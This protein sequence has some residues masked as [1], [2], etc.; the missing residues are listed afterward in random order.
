M[1]QDESRRAISGRQTLNTAPAKRPAIPASLGER[2]SRL[3][4]V[5]M[6]VCL[7]YAILLVQEGFVSGQSG[8]L[9]P[10]WVIFLL[11]LI[12]SWL[13]RGLNR[14]VELGTGTPVLLWIRKMLSRLVT[15]CALL[16]GLAFC[17]W[18]HLYAQHF[19]LFD[20][21][22]LQAFA[23][24][25]G[26]LDTMPQVLAFLVI[27]CIIA[28]LSYLTTTRKEANG[29]LLL[30]RGGLLLAGLAALSLVESVFGNSPDY[31]QAFLLLPIFCW[32]G[33]TTQSLQ[34]ASA[35][36]RY[37]AVRLEGNTRYQ[38]RIIFRVM[39]LFGLLVLATILAVVQVHGGVLPPISRMISAPVLPI[40]SD[41]TLVPQS[42]PSVPM[43][44]PHKLISNRVFQRSSSPP[45]LWF[46]LL[47]IGIG[48]LFV[49]LLVVLLRYWLKRRKRR[50]KVVQ[51]DKVESIW[52]WSLF[53][54][55]FRVLLQS[56]LRALFQAVLSLLRP[57]R[58]RLQASGIPLVGKSHPPVPA[59]HTIRGLYRAFL[60]AAELR[61]YRRAPAETPHEFRARL[62]NQEP[63]IDPEL[64]VLTE[65]YTL[66][67]YGGSVP[68]VDELVRIEESWRNLESKW[69]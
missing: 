17:L 22:W 14:F 16:L 31:W 43:P 67:R 7:V 10:I 53:L 45:P 36:R 20:S 55:Q 56:Q 12:F 21:T 57:L 3:L 58:A 54:T 23:S 40:S 24:D 69:E 39:S 47:I 65:A 38:E 26:K 8:P 62:G 18:L 63:L 4:I 1:Q 64:G 35:K 5:I 49:G 33:L 61:G 32:S 15:G 46:V 42:V 68:E 60:R 11:L 28:G 41:G 48:L 6:A 9:L 19:A 44:D 51:R 2:L 52:T 30:N 66:A 50:V 37:H 29:A 34:K 13:A 25:A 59:L 27:L